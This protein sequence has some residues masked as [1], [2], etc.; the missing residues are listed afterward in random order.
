[1]LVVQTPDQHDPNRLYLGTATDT[2]YTVQGFTYKPNRGWG[3][4]YYRAYLRH[5]GKRIEDTDFPTL[6]NAIKACESHY[7][8]N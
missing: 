6:V 5:N 4:I 1:M 7:V 3:D 2:L 8:A